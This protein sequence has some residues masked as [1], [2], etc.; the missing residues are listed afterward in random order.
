MKTLHKLI[1][2]ITCLFFISTQFI[3]AQTE[4]SIVFMR[5]NT[6][7]SNHDNK[8]KLTL[9]EAENVSI[10]AL[11]STGKKKCPKF[12]KPCPNKPNPKAD[13]EK[14][15]I[16][17][18]NSEEHPVMLIKGPPESDLSIKSENDQ[19]AIEDAKKTETPENTIWEI[20]IRTHSDLSPVLLGVEPIGR[21]PE[22]GCYIL[23]DCTN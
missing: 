7:F 9:R 11:E 5:L 15:S 14:W 23:V 2:A 22:E 1:V 6:K 13:L 20:P 10:P 12:V 3:V 21:K 16:L 19:I 17:L 18:T 8:L 4:D